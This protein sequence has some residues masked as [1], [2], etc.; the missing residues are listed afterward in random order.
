MDSARREVTEEERMRDL[1][2]NVLPLTAI[3]GVVA[4]AIAATWTGAQWKLALDSNT[5][6][7]DRLVKQ[8]GDTWS[9]DDHERWAEL[10]QQLNPSLRLP[11]RIRR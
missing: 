5:Q 8:I 11:P 9:K 1:R 10:L 2:Q 4:C 7:I 3:I 6:A